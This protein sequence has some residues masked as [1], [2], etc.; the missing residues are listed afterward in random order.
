MFNSV[1]GTS[2][3]KPKAFFKGS[4]ACFPFQLT[5]ADIMMFEAFEHVLSSMP[6]VLDKYPRLQK[7][8]KKVQSL[9]KLQE[10]LSKRKVTAF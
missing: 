1:F 5:F 6:E 4:K 10:Y 8:R 2:N 7:C 9:K 3:L